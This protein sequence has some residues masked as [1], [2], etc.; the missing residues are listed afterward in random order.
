MP[1]PID[2]NDITGVV[3]LLRWQCTN[4]D[5]WHSAPLGPIHPTTIE[6]LREATMAGA[7]LDQVQPGSAHVVLAIAEQGE[8]WLATFTPQSATQDWTPS[9]AYDNQIAT[10][11][12]TSV[13]DGLTRDDVI[14]R[15]LDPAPT[16]LAAM[17]AAHAWVRAHAG[18]RGE[19]VPADDDWTAAWAR[20][21]D[22]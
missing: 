15:T 8:G 11:V 4:C 7:A 1:D 16:L 20:K 18:A 9:V 22:S 2:A 17:N 12:G 3:V 21:L 13:E 10:L 6:M 5:R 14:W 19:I